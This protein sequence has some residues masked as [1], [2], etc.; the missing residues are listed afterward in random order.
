VLEIGL[1]GL[2]PGK[3]SFVRIYRE[4]SSDY[5]D[6]AT[7]RCPFTQAGKLICESSSTLS[8]PYNSKLHFPPPYV[9]CSDTGNDVRFDISGVN[10]FHYLYTLLPSCQDT[11]L[12]HVYPMV[13]NYRVTRQRSLETTLGA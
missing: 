5:L 12:V 10:A 3:V 8:K 13:A 1:D 7:R 2:K 6:A 4:G 11:A 9:P